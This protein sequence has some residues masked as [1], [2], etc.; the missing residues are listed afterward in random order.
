MKLISL[1]VANLSPDVSEVGT[2]IRN[3]FCFVVAKFIK[4]IQEE[5]MERIF[6]GFSLACEEKLD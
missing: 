6:D 3:D 4:I 2:H 1:N 5:G